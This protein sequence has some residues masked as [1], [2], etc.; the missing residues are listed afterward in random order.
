MSVMV[1]KNF[2]KHPVVENRLLLQEV[3]KETHMETEAVRTKSW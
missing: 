1:R 2:R 3:V